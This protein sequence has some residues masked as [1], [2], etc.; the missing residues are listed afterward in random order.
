MKTP[1]TIILL[2]VFCHKNSVAQSPSEL[3]RVL[4]RLSGDSKE[5]RKSIATTAV[6]S[7]G[8]NALI[9]LSEIFT[10]TTET[11]VYSKCQFRYLS[12]G[13]LAIIV[14][15]HI[16]GMPYALLT[17]VQNCLWQFCYDNPNR[18]EFYLNAVQLKGYATFKTDYLE[19]LNKQGN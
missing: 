17:D 2:V 9:P 11:S 19:W 18:I 13:E 5:I 12:K 7:Y 10:D 6:I 4:D 15:D 14:A 16:K 3:S 1:F 8:Q